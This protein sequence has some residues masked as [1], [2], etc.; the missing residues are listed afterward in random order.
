MERWP[1]PPTSIAKIAPLRMLK[2]SGTG[3]C[4]YVVI[5]Y[6]P[7]ME[8][9]ARCQRSPSKDRERNQSPSAISNNA[10]LQ[11]VPSLELPVKTKF[12]SPER[13][14]R[15]K[16]KLF[17]KC[18][19]QRYFNSLSTAEKFRRTDAAFFPFFLHVTYTH[20]L[21]NETAWL[22][23]KNRESMQKWKITILILLQVRNGLNAIKAIVR[24]LEHMTD[25]SEA[26]F[27]TPRTK[28]IALVHKRESACTVLPSA[29]LW[30]CSLLYQK[31]LSGAYNRKHLTICSSSITTCPIVGTSAVAAV[32]SST[33]PIMNNAVTIQS[34]LALTFVISVI[35]RIH[36]IVE[37]IRAILYVASR[38]IISSGFSTAT[39]RGITISDNVRPGTK[40]CVGRS[41][42]GHWRFG[43]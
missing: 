33:A 7:D 17:V 22:S 4:V 23:L 35:V 34:T 30:C 38:I 40:R 1:I 20:I 29:I 18:T 28:R 15:G 26:L 13:E 11:E 12:T 36:S 3:C 32:A 43:Y 16:P 9:I 19:R 31:S 41:G 5:T 21:I 27:I 25:L 2:Y 14:A 42:L 37:T 39:P 6:F 24:S 10:G 8:T